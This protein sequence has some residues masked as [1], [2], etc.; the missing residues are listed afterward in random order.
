MDA[1]GRGRGQVDALTRQCLR[2]HERPV[3]K[4]SPRLRFELDT[5]ITNHTQ[6][7]C[8]TGRSTL[9]GWRGGKA[10]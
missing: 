4:T 6:C 9:Y 3:G 2:K 1:R 8:A 10:P 7:N 5:P